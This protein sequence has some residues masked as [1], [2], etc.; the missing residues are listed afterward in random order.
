VYLDPRTS[1][2]AAVVEAARNV[3]CV[4][5]RPRAITK[6]LNFGSPRQPEMFFQFKEAVA[7]MGDACRALETPVTGG[8]VSF[9]NESP[10]SSVY[11]T[12]VVG[13][14]GLIE[15]LEHVTRSTFRDVGDAIVLLGEPRDEIGGSEYLARIHGVVAGLPPRVDLAAERALVDALLGAISAGLVNSAHYCS[16]GGLAVGLAECCI[17]DSDVQLG[18][19]VDLSAWSSLPMRALLFGET[20]GRVIVSTREPDAVVAVARGC[21]VPARAI[22]TVTEA[23]ELVLRVRSRVLRAPLASLA[24]SYHDAIPRIMDAGPTS[25]AVVQE[26]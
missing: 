13:M 3:A 8:N 2:Q 18:A 20:H 21:G 15:S 1:G 4:G 25:A 14:V 11:P 19:D 23:E 10:I 6:N 16:D 5:G 22:G 9:Y 26:R 17:M 7:G 24:D 12:P